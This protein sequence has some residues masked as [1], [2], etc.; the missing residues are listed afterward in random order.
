MLANGATHPSLLATTLQSTLVWV[1]RMATH[2]FLSWPT[3]QRPPPHIQGPLS[4]RVTFPV[5]ANTRTVNSVLPLDA[6]KMAALL[7]FSP[8]KKR[9]L[10]ICVK[11]LIRL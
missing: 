11:L 3:S 5:P 7:V 4:Y 1:Q 2:G 10:P 9:P 6:I 8:N